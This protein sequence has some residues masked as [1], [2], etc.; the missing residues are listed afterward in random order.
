MGTFLVCAIDVVALNPGAI[1][2]QDVEIVRPEPPRLEDFETDADKDGTPDGWYNLRDA[3]LVEAGGV[4]GPHFLRFEN[5][6]PGRPARL[7]RAFG[8]NGKKT[9]AVIIGFWLRLESIQMGERLGEDPAF[10]IDFLGDEL[11]TLG[12]GS[13]GP[14]PK[15]SPGTWTRVAKRIAVPPGTQDAIISVGLLGATGTM[16]VDGL[17]IDLVPAGGSDTTNLVVNGDFELGDPEPA[18]WLLDHGA[19]RVLGRSP[20]GAALELARPGARAMTGLAP[21]VANF[22]QLELSLMVKGQGLRGAGGGHV[23]VFFLEPEGRLFGGMQAGQIVDRWSGTFDWQPDRV[24]VPVPRSAMRAVIQF[25]KPDGNG[26]L[27]L[28]DVKVQVSPNPEAGTWKPYHVEDDTIGWKAVASSAAIDANSPLDASYLLDPPAGKHGFVTVR[29]RRLA[30][31]KAGRARFFGV[32]LQAPVPFLDRERADKL[33]D[34]LAR[35]GINLVRLG[36]LD[37]SLGPQRSLFEDSRDDTKEFDPESLARLDHLIAALKARGIYVALELQ[38]VRKY[39]AGDGGPDAAVLPPG[40][41]P[42]AFFDPALK[43]RQFAA[44]AQLLGHYNPETK[45]ALRDDPVLAWVTLA[46]ETSM[47]DQ[48]DNPAALPGAFAAELKGLASRGVYGAGRR[49]WQYLESEHLKD[50]AARLRKGRVQVPIAGVSHWRREPEFV[51]AQ[52][53][54]GLDLIDDRLYWNPPPWVDPE[55]CSILFSHNGALAA[56]ANLKRK[57]DRP[58]VVGQWCHQTMGAWAF[59]YEAA[60]LMLASLLAL[61]EDWDALVRRGVFVYP[62]KWGANSA[63][64]GGGEDIYQMP[65]V[66]NGIP[67]VFALWPHAASLLLRGHTTGPATPKAAPHRVGGTSRVTAVPSWNP[68]QGRLVIDTQYTQGLAGWP[69]PE[70]AEFENLQVKIDQPYGVVVVSSAGK[71]PIAGSNRLLVTAIARVEPTGYRWVD[72]WKRD[73]ADPGRA[74]LLQEPVVARVRWRRKGNIKAHGLDNNGARAFPMTL[75]TVDDGVVLNIVG[76]S[77]TFHWELVVE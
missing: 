35:S 19:Q 52:A 5:Q 56:G 36:D 57:T 67:Q 25:E 65:E 2:A 44:A 69:G 4:V 32:S 64:T 72:T 15:V 63:G 49:F 3:R 30:F 50:F 37:T 29:D 26:V 77:P 11:R 58:Y 10:V 12:R 6:R 55:R 31:S 41:G 75:E 51:A 34:R 13:L 16:D 70:P 1:W 7:S 76:N 54:P 21:P 18:S 48:I 71:A 39:R 46:G 40:G 9:E 17:T 59:R 60:D 62:E 68:D 74:P 73:V 38:S 20:A 43:D 14:W 47:F 23:L 45:L 22:I 24:V 33:V 61:H 27:L 66:V 8:I 28:D 42:A 53:T